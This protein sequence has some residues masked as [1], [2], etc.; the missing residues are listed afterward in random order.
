MADKKMTVYELGGEWKAL[1]SLLDELT[2]PETG[3]TRELTEEEKVYFTDM[4]NEIGGN[5]KNKADG[6][7][8]VYCNKKAEAEIAE[9]EK[10]ALK[11]EMERLRKR[12]EARFNEASR[13]KGLLSYLMDAMKLKKIKTEIFS[14]G[15]QATQKSVKPV[16]GFFNP[17]L[18]P[19]EFLKREINPTA[20]KKAVEEGLLYEKYKKNEDGTEENPQ[21]RGKLFYKENCVE[22]QLNYV[23]YLSGETLVIR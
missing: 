18:I 2:D 13:V 15:Y 14:A 9:A 19:V 23:S 21:D 3:E 8:K 16:E 7:Y 1:L 11:N 4:T 10:N 12:A 5:I 17:D 22:R 6:I 20:V